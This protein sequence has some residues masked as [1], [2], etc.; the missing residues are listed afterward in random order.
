MGFSRIL[1]LLL[2]FSLG[3]TVF[4]KTGN[5]L[6][7]TCIEY[8]KGILMKELKKNGVIKEDETKRSGG[9]T[10]GCKSDSKLDTNLE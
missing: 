10:R 9:H 7:N 3:Y 6:A 5:S 4:T 1:S 8:G 2:G